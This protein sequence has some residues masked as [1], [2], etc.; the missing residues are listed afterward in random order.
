MDYNNVIL[1]LK[2]ETCIYIH[3]RFFSKV[4]INLDGFFE[5]KTGNWKLEIWANNWEKA[6]RISWLM[7][8]H[9]V[10]EVKY[11]DAVI[12]IRALDRPLVTRCY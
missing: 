1:Q 11:Y 8:I 4:L 10:K 5:R 7:L 6:S 2:I 12:S 9:E 3:L